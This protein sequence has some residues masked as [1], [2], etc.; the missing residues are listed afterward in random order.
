MVYILMA[1]L[2]LALA[3]G[4]GLN[5]FFVYTVCIAFGLIFYI[6]ISVFSGNVKKVKASSWVIAGLFIAMLLLTH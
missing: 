5:A 1:N 3:S 4:M 2:P 6:T